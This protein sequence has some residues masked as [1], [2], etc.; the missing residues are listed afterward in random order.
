M[1]IDINQLIDI[2][3]SDPIYRPLLEEIQG[4]ILAGYN[5]QNTVLLVLT[6]NNNIAATKQWIGTFSNQYVTS[7]YAQSAEG[8]TGLVANFFLSMI[9]YMH[10][11]FAYGDVPQGA[12]FRGGMKDPN[13]KELLGDPPVDQW[14]PAYQPELHGMVLLADDDVTALNTVVT[15]LQQ[16]LLDITS[17]IHLENGF[18]M[19]NANG[20]A[21]EHFG[22]RDGISQP[23]FLKNQIDSARVAQGGF[24]NWDPRASLSL[25]LSKDPL[26]KTEDSYGSFLVYRKLQKDVPGFE[27]NLKT[28]G[29]ALGVDVELA[30]AFTIGRFKD[31]TPVTLSNV[32]DGESNPNFNDFNYQGDQQGSRCPFFA[33]TRKVNPRGDTE[34]LTSTPV[35]LPEEKMHRIVRRGASYGAKPPEPAGKTGSGSLF[36]CFMADIANQ[37]VVMQNIWAN[38]PNFVV[39]NVGTDPI[40]GVEKLD[41]NGQ[42]V[43]EEYE[44]PNPWGT[45]NR[46]TTDFTHWVLFQ[47]GEYFFTPSLS[48]LKSLS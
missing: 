16:E 5:R 6:F 31:G 26:G 40:I 28:L 17:H 14:E 47:G 1:A 21:I 29:D 20:Q 41:S 30:G 3:P 44:F 19:H 15:Q 12:Y 37:F 8:K 4:N 13:A 7:A 35:P 25:V 23:L 36:L 43:P 42:P 39:Q 10:L 48:F 9:G 11:Q 24:E 2:D 34:T 32:A 46:K 38:N 22:F 45:T 18:V 33:H 27:A